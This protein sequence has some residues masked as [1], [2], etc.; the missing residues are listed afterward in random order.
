[1]NDTM[2]EA[3]DFLYDLPKFT[4]KNSLDH[5]RK[6]M[7]LLGS[8]CF[9][10][11]VIHVA[12]SNGK[13]SVCSYLYHML[14]AAG[15][16]AALF[17]SPH[18]VDI[19]ERFQVNGNLVS[20]EEF[21][22]AYDRVRAASEELVRN[23]LNHPT[24]FEFIFA[25]GMVI[26]EKAQ[27]E[28]IVL[29]TGLGG[30]LDATN[31]YPHPILTVITSISLEHMEIL[32]DSIEKIAAEK[33]GILKP[34]VPVVY[35][36]AEEETAR[37]IRTR[38][39]ET[40]CPQIAVFKKMFQN[41]EIK[42]N[43][44]EFLLSTAYDCSNWNVPGHAVYQV[45]NASLA[46]T[47]MHV[48][49]VADNA[50]LQRGLQMT[51]WPGRMQEVLPEIYFDGAHNPS[52]IEAFVTSVRLLTKGDIYP[53][54]LLFSMVKEKDL[55]AAA[56]LLAAG[57]NWESIAVTTVAG[58]RGVPAETLCCLFFADG[59]EAACPVESIDDAREAFRVMQN[60]K[61]PGQKLF[62]TGSL[63]FIGNLLETLI[64]E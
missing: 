19:R 59:A 46:I 18:L 35:L 4:T 27:T 6:L 9:N 34:G 21:L 50:T 52:G 17:T 3:V 39:Q 44:I 24:F 25:M 28:Y 48:L 47:A 33:A 43:S 62:C 12:G 49:E 26:F 29:E 38:A 56:G 2:R 7:E 22:A 32:G 14:L 42:E 8:P 1:M 54:L 10:R 20:E 5:T 37:V 23:N 53:P 45:E 55:H 51:E 61:K 63:Y 11:K 57:V 15:K 31:S 16:S 41:Y 60:R 58:E 36:D 30:R 64:Q 13:G 40:G